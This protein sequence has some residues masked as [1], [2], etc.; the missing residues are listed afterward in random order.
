MQL[1]YNI[2]NKLLCFTFQNEE[3]LWF[4][5]F[6]TF[7]HEHRFKTAVVQR[8]CKNGRAKNDPYLISF[9]NARITTV[10][11]LTANPI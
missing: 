1:N 3:V 6:F 7:G 10:A 8:R 4:F 11:I 5:F 2:L 9:F